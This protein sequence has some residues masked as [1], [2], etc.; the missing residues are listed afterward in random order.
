M[1]IL[2]HKPN[3]NIRQVNYIHDTQIH[4]FRLAI[5][6]TIIYKKFKTV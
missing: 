4:I 3:Y 6:R 5:N 1:T 2:N